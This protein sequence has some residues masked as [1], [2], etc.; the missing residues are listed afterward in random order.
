MDSH[1]A[2]SV[3]GNPVT[4]FEY[5]NSLQEFARQLFG[6]GSAELAPGQLKKA[7]ELARER[8]IAKELLYQAALSR[9]L[10]ASEQDVADEAQKMIA[11]FPKE[12]EFFEKLVQVDIDQPTFWRI[13]RKDMTVNLISS[14][15]LEEAS[16]PDIAQIEEIYRKYPQFMK[17][18]EQVSAHHILIKIDPAAGPAAKDQA[19]ERID[20]ILA[21]CM[22]PGADFCQLAYESSDCPSASKGGDLGLFKRGDM[23]KAFED[24]AFSQPLGVVGPIIETDYGFHL[25]RVDEFIAEKNLSLEEASGKIRTYLKE[26][27]GALALKELTEGL[28]KDA[29]IESFI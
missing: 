27:A 26:D 23:I 25:L 4:R 12:E 2:L 14:T 28:R 9:G 22:E 29:A 20:S 21:Q 13:M 1:I 15:T 11:Q 5:D 17:V 6:K 10:I 7:D 18:A 19:Q 3:N 24:S 16:D 8:L